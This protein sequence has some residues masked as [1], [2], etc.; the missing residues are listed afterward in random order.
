MQLAVNYFIHCSAPLQAPL[1]ASFQSRSCP[2]ALAGGLPPVER[3]EGG[4]IT[5][6]KGAP[7]DFPDQNYYKISEEDSW[8]VNKIDQT[9]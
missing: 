2:S 1:Q 4:R 3:D 9:A 6:S 7:V 8:Q 5:S